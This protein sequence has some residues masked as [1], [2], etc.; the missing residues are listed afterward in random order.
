VKQKNS[1]AEAKQ[2]IHTSPTKKFP[3]AAKTK[4]CEIKTNNCC[5]QTK[6]QKN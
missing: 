3:A 2:E 5:S 6:P 1:P 4:S